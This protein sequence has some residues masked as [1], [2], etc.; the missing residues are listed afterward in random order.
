MNINQACIDACY[1]CASDCEV[2][3]DAMLVHSLDGDCPRRCRE[4][5]DLCLY[6]AQSL[7]RNSQFAGEL[8]AVCEK[9]CHW[10]AEACEV[11]DHYHCQICA[12]SCRRCAEACQQLVLVA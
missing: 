7:A 4:S 9:I 1:K 2:C 12:D 3:L 6:C 10:C 5:I 11:H 8:C